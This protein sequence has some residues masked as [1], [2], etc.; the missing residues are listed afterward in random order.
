MKLYTW[1]ETTAHRGVNE[2]VS[3]LNHYIENNIPNTVRKLMVF[4]DGCRGQNHNHT[5]V[6][7]FSSLVFS[8]K[9]DIIV[10]RLPVRGHSY[11][12]CDRQFGQIEKIQRRH[13]TVETYQGWE[14]II[15]EKFELISMKCT[16]IFYFKSH[17]AQFYKKS[18]IKNGV[19]YLV[20][21]YKVFKFTNDFKND[22]VVSESM[23]FVDP[24]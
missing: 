19:K 13:E 15:S 10:H 8:G 5:M 20:S 3:C 12:P 6:Q 11:L 24:I 7:Y 1:P 4:T 18:V 22:V 9:F 16:D 2:V 23:S 14:A 17:L 21:K